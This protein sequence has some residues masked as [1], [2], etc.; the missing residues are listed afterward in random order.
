MRLCICYGENTCEVKG[1]VI[2]KHSGGGMG[3]F[4]MGVLFRDI[5]TE[6][7]HLIEDWLTQLARQ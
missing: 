1:K 3:V 2:Y 6:Q 7:H 4:G 5:S